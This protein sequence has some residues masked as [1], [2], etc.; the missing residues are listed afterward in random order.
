M[1]MDY[2]ARARE[3]AHV[4]LY[5][6]TDMQIRTISDFLREAHQQGREAA[7][8]EMAEYLKR[9]REAYAEDLA[10][11]SLNIEDIDPDHRTRVAFRMGRFVLDNCIKD[12]AALKGPKRG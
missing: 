3:L 4:L 12:V 10:P 9:Y 2:E 8:D 5:Q 7:C 6:P 1:T 11:G